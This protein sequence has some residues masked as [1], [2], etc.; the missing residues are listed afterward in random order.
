MKA[1]LRITKNTVPRMLA[2]YIGRPGKGKYWGLGLHLYTDTQLE[3]LD[4]IAKDLVCELN[5]ITKQ[6]QTAIQQEIRDRKINKIL[7]C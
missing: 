2:S 3:K 4:S 5:G 1:T 7:T 6:L